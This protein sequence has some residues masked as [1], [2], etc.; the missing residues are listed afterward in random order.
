MW[1]QIFVTLIFVKHHYLGMFMVN[2]VREKID[3][4]VKWNVFQ[5]SRC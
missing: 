1:R 5:R 2:D 4:G 3:G